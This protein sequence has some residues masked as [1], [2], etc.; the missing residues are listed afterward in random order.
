MER[1]ILDLFLYNQKLKFSDIEHQIKERS[2]KLAYHLKQLV[3]KGVLEKSN[4]SYSLS[5]TALTLIPYLSN[6]K[7]PLPVLLI[8]IGNKNS[9]FLYKRNKRPYKDKLSLPGG[10][11]LLSEDIEKATKRIIKEKFNIQVKLKK[12]N[13]ASLEHVKKNKKIIHSF[14]LVFVTATTQNNVKLTNIK[15]NKNKIISSD[16]KLLTSNLDFEI[17]IKNIETFL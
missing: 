2:N 6:K 11:L 10:R 3:K 7:S 13:S 1:K 4:N 17:N 16:Y 14:L 5:E 15:N 9:C 12:I 8:H